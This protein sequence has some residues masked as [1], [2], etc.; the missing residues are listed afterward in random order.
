MDPVLLGLAGAAGAALIQA[1]TTDAWS[2]TRRHFLRIIGRCNSGERDAL[3]EELDASAIK[4]RQEASP[5]AANS[6][7][8]ARWT[9]FL[10]DFLAEHRDAAVD[11]RIFVAETRRL[12]ASE[13]QSS[14]IQN[15]TAGRDAYIAGRDQHIIRS[16]GDDERGN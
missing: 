7:E 11:L 4:L 15:L 5:E 13:A 6:T 1:M 8:Q 16:V 14:V 2:S 12:L 3:H 9:K 10:E